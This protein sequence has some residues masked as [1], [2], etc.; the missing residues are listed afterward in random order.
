[1]TKTVETLEAED[2]AEKPYDASD[3]KQVNEARKK[4]GRKKKREREFLHTMMQHPDGRFLMYDMVRCVVEGNPMVP[5]DP[6]STYFNLG[7]EYK[8]RALFREIA[9]ISPDQLVLMLQENT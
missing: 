3:P 7:Q 2:L 1:M 9:K 4:G 5:G 6:H 8:A